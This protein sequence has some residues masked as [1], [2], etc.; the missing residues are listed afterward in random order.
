MTHPRFHTRE[1]F[2][3]IACLIALVVHCGVVSA[4]GSQEGPRLRVLTYNIHHGE[5]TDGEFDY[6]RLSKMINDL[7][8]D[9][10][11][12]QEVDYEANRSHGVDQTQLLGQLTELGAV[13][14]Q[15]LPFPEGAYG[16][17]VLS[18]FPI[19]KADVNPLPFKVGHEPRAAFAT[20]IKPDNGLPSFVFVS[21]HLSHQG[22]EER[23]DQ[24]RQINLLF[25][26]EGEVPHIVAGDFNAR[27]GSD[28]MNL[29]L[30]ERWV[31][32]VAPKSRIDYVLARSTDPW[33]VTEVN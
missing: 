30:K 15:T 10:V 22:A 9:V 31:D 1:R 27:V 20:L 19:E 7:R 3:V 11:A 26:A 33:K 21:T 25:P 5:G 2:S 14:G 6:M 29:L 12:L 16:L 24:A 8:P 17:A 32:T 18:R 23:A 28:A 4:Q 13:F